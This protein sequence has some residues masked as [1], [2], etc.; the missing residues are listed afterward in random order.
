MSNLISVIMPVRNAE[1]WIKECLE[2]IQAQSLTNWELIVVDDHSDDNS[3]EITQSASVEDKRI[4]AL[5]NDGSGIIQALEKA[6]KSSSG[7][8]ITRMDADDIMP[9]NKLDLLLK[10]LDSSKTSVSTGKVE[11]FSEDVITEGYRTYEAWI[12]QRVE[13]QDHDQ[14]IYRECTIAGA[15]WMTHRDNLKWGDL[16]YPEDY[17]LVFHW[18]KIGCS[19]ICV[20]QVT[21]QW[22]DH[23]ARTSKNSQNY[24]QKAFF[25]LKINRFIEM[26]MDNSKSLFILGDNRKSKLATEILKEGDIEFK[27]IGKDDID[28]LG[29]HLEAQVLVAVFPPL[30]ERNQIRKFLSYNR[31][32]EGVNWW[33]L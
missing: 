2:S 9:P 13:A 10:T 3:L 29:P 20:D 21:H 22:R 30:F 5:S 27:V 16:K 8:W 18:Y 28:L 15:N 14:W 25:K 1:P 17:D 12:N 32:Q 31:F 24:K 23:A 11:Y 7:T 4:R 6:I 26:D 19:I 33:W